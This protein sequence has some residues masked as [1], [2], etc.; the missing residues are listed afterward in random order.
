MV[1]KNW[2]DKVESIIK[3]CAQAQLPVNVEEDTKPDG[4]D[5]YLEL[6]DIP[7]EKMGDVYDLDLT[8]NL[9]FSASKNIWKPLL[10]KLM[11]LT[12]RL[13]ADTYRLV[14]GWVREDDDSKIVYNGTIIIK[15]RINSDILV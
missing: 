2:T 14:G 3:I 11:I 7:L 13:T 9:K 1:D 15:G 4:I 6:G 12:E 5:G 8:I 10:H